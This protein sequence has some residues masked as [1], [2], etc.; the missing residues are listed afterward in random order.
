MKLRLNPLAASLVLASMFWAACDLP[1]AWA[2]TPQSMSQ[3]VAA[4]AQRN[5]PEWVDVIVV[6]KA[7]PSPSERA[8]IEALGGENQRAYG[9]LN[10]RSLSVPAQRLH[11]LANNP[12]IE[13]ITLDEPVTAFSAAARYTAHLPDPAQANAVYDGSGVK[14]AVIDSGVFHHGDFAQPISQYDFVNGGS[15]VFEQ[16]G[17]IHRLDTAT[18]DI[19]LDRVLITN[20][21]PEPLGN[22]VNSYAS[23][24]PV[25][26]EGRVYVH[27]GGYGTFC[28][29][30]V[31]HE[32]A[33]G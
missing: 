19:L 17:Y 25:I 6:Y 13:Y 23:P 30:T 14:V 10:M 32:A 15:L 33:R 5:G 20:D 18:G 4:L 28:L 31:S 7:T 16:A 21:N 27:F 12:N 22:P 9:R 1:Q 2:A 3:R 29:D 8:R 26:E 24:S 11:A